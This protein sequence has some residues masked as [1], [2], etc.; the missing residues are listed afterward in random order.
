MSAMSASCVNVR[1][2]WGEYL[3]RD[4]TDRLFAKRFIL[5]RN[6]SESRTPSGRSL[7]QSHYFRTE[8]Y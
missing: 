8:L 2:F 7:D 3:I 4:F 6:F 5:D 1:F